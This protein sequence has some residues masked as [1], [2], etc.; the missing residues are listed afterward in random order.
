MLVYQTAQHTNFSRAAEPDI[1]SYMKSTFSHIQFNIDFANALFYKDL[2]KFLGWAEIYSDEN[3]VGFNND[4]ENSASI[5]F[6]K[7]PSTDIQKHHDIGAN[8]IGLNVPEQTDVDATVTYLADKKIDP[9]YSTPRHRPE[10][11]FEKDTTYYQVMFESP[12][13]ILFE[14]MYTGKKI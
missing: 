1:I 5:W 11:A 2:M 4:T 6:I 8:H 3:V 7:G 9:L 13:K 10:F 12:D 14:I